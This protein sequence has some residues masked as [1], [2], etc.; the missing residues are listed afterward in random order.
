[1]TLPSSDNLIGKQLRD[2]Y[3]RYSGIIVGINTDESGSVC[4]IGVDAGCNGFQTIGVDQITFVDDNPVLVSN[5]KLKAESLIKTSG[6]AQKRIQALEELHREGEISQTVYEQLISR[7]KAQFD[8]CLK[9]CDDA[10]ASLN[11]KATVLQNER[12]VISAFFGVLKLQHRIQEI[13]DST[14]KSTSEHIESILQR[15]DKESKD[16]SAILDSLTLQEPEPDVSAPVAAPTPDETPETNTCEQAAEAVPSAPEMVSAATSDATPTTV[17]EVVSVDAGAQGS[18]VDE[19]VYVEDNSTLGSEIPIETPETLE[20]HTEPASNETTDLSDHMPL[21]DS[22]HAEETSEASQTASSDIADSVS[23]ETTETAPEY[24]A[25][26]P[27]KVNKTPS[28]SEQSSDDNTV[29]PT[30]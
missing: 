29:C 18:E 15:N 27:E 14:Y 16:I 1:M 6:A 28:D 17:E 25:V 11:E 4:S 19:N 22:V 8:L 26:T 3:G 5:W 21:D 13:D 9:N 10:V 23:F 20:A 12:N 30:Q 2:S 7:S 24:A